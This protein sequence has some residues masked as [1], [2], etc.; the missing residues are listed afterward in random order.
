MELGVATWVHDLRSMQKLVL[1]TVR[2]GLREDFP[3]AVA[4]LGVTNLRLARRLAQLT[5]GEIEE[6]CEGLGPRLAVRLDES[7]AVEL[8]ISRVLE[9]EEDQVI[10]RMA[11]A[12]TGT[13]LH[14]TPAGAEA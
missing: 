2:E 7:L 4:L 1:M 8:L 12:A 11:A 9:T 10:C 6:L 3:Q 13:S 14:V 5:V